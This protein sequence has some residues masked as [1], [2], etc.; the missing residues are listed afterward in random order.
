MATLKRD[1][2]GDWILRFWTNG[3]RSRLAHHN[4][5]ELSHKDAKDRAKVLMA[6]SDSLKKFADP[7]INFKRLSE[8][9]LKLHAA[10]NLGKRTFQRTVAIVRL[11]LVPASGARRVRD[12]LPVDV[13]EFT[14]ATMAAA[15]ARRRP[16]R[17]SASAS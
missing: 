8:Q 1:R 15:D 12:L 16:R 2:P 14:R 10:P 17:T 7:N 4:L 3:R 13:E 11:H 6:E 9:W 5:G